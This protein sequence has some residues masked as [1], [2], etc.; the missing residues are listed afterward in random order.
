MAQVAPTASEAAAYSGLHAA[1]QQGDVAKIERLA[2]SKADLNVRDGN[3]RTPLH[4]ASFA[5]QRHAIHA[6]VMAGADIHLLDKDRYDGV[7]IASVADDD[8]TLRVLLSLV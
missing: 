1:A 2:A 8:D 6:L 4:V 7:T 5:K 3:G